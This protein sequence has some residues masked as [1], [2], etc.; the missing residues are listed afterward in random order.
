MTPTFG[1][2]QLSLVGDRAGQ[3][4]R[5]FEELARYCGGSVQGRVF[6]EL[7]PP[8]E[9]WWKMLTPGNREQLR[10]TAARREIVLNRVLGSPPPTT[11]LWMLLDALA[12]CDGEL[13][14]LLVPSPQ[15]FDGL[16]VP[17]DLMLRRMSDACPSLLVVYADSPAT[18]LREGRSLARL[19]E[20]SLDDQPGTLVDVTVGAFADPVGVVL[21]HTHWGL[22]RAGLSS[23]VQPVDSLMRLLVGAAVSHVTAD[24]NRLQV[25]VVRPPLA[26]TLAV[27][28]WESRD[29]SDEPVSGEVIEL[30]DPD[31]GGTVKRHRSP[32]GGTL[33]RCELALPGS[34]RT[35]QVGTAEL[36]AVLHEY[37]AGIS[38]WLIGDPSSSTRSV[39]HRAAASKAEA[40]TEGHQN[41]SATR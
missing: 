14:Y 4:M 24:A 26:A 1:Y 41:V 25:R 40:S 16:G 38:D 20:I 36:T 2:L 10:A 17:R 30:V 28:V 39:C 23:L 18:Q 8:A 6:A 22:S 31:S 3:V 9:V 19:G 32:A 35:D 7:E 11:A 15:H 33:T 21:S 27:E 37:V 5:M 34:E 12:G 29:H 13:T